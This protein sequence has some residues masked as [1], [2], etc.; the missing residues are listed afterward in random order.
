MA[1]DNA[2]AAESRAASWHGR[3][4]GLV[5]AASEELE[6]LSEC[7]PEP[8][9]ATTNWRRVAEI[10]ELADEWPGV[11]V[12]PLVNTRFP[13]GRLML[14]IDTDASSAYLVEA[15][16]YGLHVVSADGT[17]ITSVL[18][19]RASWEWQRL[20][21]AQALPLAA[22]AH[23][24]EPL[25]ASAVGIAGRAIAFT[26]PSGTGKTSI[27]MHLV[28]R[29]AGLLTDDV[30]AVETTPSQLLAHPG[31]RL[32]NADRAELAEL[33]AGRERLGPALGEEEKVQMRPPVEPAPLPLAALYKLVREPAG[34]R[35]RIVQEVPPDS[36]ELLATG[37][38]TYLKSPERLTRHLDFASRMAQGVPLFVVHLPA[39]LSAA[40]SAELLE[41]H[42]V[43]AV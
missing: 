14:S 32:L 2:V 37:F 28:A 43:T 17:R 25:H 30:L 38:L 26:A 34:T 20:L 33:H 42:I 11:D 10:E 24:F 41:Q 36:R 29:G 4:F 18:R 1:R 9:A 21:A 16:G 23:G 13:D 39:D 8:G 3:A 35:L 40:R 6:T 12:K 7:P 31:V 27:A 22:A 5:V 15:P 19:P